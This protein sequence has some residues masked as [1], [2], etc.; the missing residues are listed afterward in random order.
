MS[1]WITANLSSEKYFSM[2]FD[3]NIM[4]DAIESIILGRSYKGFLEL[5]LDSFSETVEDEGEAIT[6]VKLVLEFDP[7]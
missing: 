1:Q 7:M 5:G 4:Y 6:L 2:K 3:N